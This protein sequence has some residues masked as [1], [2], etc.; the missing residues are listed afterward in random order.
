MYT[1]PPSHPPLCFPNFY[2]PFP[3]LFRY[4]MLVQ[5][6]DRAAPCAGHGVKASSYRNLS[7][8]NTEPT[9]LIHSGTIVYWKS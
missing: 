8:K 7:P 6:G 9:A 5:I 1:F 4:R 3:A 2:K